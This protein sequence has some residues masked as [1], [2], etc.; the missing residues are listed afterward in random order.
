MS[1]PTAHRP[2]LVLGLALASAVALLLDAGATRAEEK[3][4][5]RTV[6]VSASGQVAVKPDLARISTGVTTEAATAR[7]AMSR[8]SEAMGKLIAGLKSAG[9]AAEDIQTSELAVGP[10]YSNPRDGKAPSIIGYQVTNQVRIA[11]RDL[12]RLGEVLDQLVS[13]GANQIGGLSFEAST[14]ETARDEA[15]RQ[16]VAN[17][18]RRAKLYAEAAGAK[19][20]QVLTISEETAHV[21]P[22]GMAMARAASAEAAPIEEGVLQ[23]EARVTITYALE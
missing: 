3:A 4:M 15:R 7:E 21:V 11:A 18:L 19:V 2:I 12:A 6:T 22:R 9:V 20:G 1:N 16:A 13:L 17:A 23:L 5:Q 8:N 14:A 10:R